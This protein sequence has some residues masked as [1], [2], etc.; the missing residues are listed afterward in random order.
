[1][2]WAPSDTYLQHFGIPGM[3]WGVRRWQN[4]DGTLNDFGRARYG[5]RYHKVNEASA[6]RQ[7]E[8]Y[9]K[10]DDYKKNFEAGYGDWKA[11]TLTGR[12]YSGAIDRA[13]KRLSKA[14]F[15]LTENVGRNLFRPSRINE[16][17]VTEVANEQRNVVRLN[18]QAVNAYLSQNAG[19]LLSAM[20]YKDTAKGRRYLKKWLMQSNQYAY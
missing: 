2:W 3:K 16:Q 17:R 5:N 11:H 15:K 13:E 9:K 19:Q 6:K 20:G 8:R 1:M 7:L 12:H 10:S 18:K 4:D 14:K